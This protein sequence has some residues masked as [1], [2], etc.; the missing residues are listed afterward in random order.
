MAS[1]EETK[2]DKNTEQEEVPATPPGVITT[3]AELEQKIVPALNADVPK[4]LVTQDLLRAILQQRF[5]NDAYMVY[6]NVELHDWTKVEQT[7]LRNAETIND[8]IFGRSKVTITDQ[9]PP[10]QGPA[11]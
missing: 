1:T 11:V 7:E 5:K 3:M 9:R 2:E 10:Q 4:L 6:R 8:R